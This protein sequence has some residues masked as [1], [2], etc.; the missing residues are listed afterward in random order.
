M[1]L[2]SLID[3]K[4]LEQ[5]CALVS[6][7]SG[8]R[9]AL[10]RSESAK[11]LYRAFALGTIPID[12]VQPIVQEF[13]E[14]FQRGTHFQYEPE[15]C[16]LAVVLEELDSDGAVN[17]LTDLADVSI[18]EM[19]MSPK[20]AAI[21]LQNRKLRPKNQVKDYGS[22][23]PIHNAFEELTAGFHRSPPTVTVHQFE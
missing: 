3:A 20:V 23:L 7:A 9:K 4:E 15:L 22:T 18:A 16:L 2:N 19:P 6:T 12:Q 17:F 1:I 5:T 8:L 13:T 11:R 21:C 10:K 14:Q